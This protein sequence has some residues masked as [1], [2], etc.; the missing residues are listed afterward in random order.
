MGARRPAQDLDPRLAQLIRFEVRTLIGRYGFTISDREDLQQDLALHLIEQMSGH[1]P[2]RGKIATF[3]DRILRNRV[4]G[5]VRHRCA[6]KRHRR[7]ERP[8]E[9]AANVPDR[10]EAELLRQHRLKLDLDQALSRLPQELADAAALFKECG[11]AE[12]VRRTGLSRQRVRT[13]R[14]RIGQHLRSQGI[15]PASCD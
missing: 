12:M 13:L 14:Q 1:D 5:I 15:G 10:G 4:V 7:V 8:L 6:G 3:A 11:E 2:G 9:D